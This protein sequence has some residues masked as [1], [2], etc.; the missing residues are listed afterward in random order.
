MPVSY[1]VWLGLALAL[2]GAAFVIRMEYVSDGARIRRALK[3]T[4][5]SEVAS[6]PE[7]QLIKLIGTLSCVGEPLRAPLSERPCSCYE[8][9]VRVEGKNGG[10]RIVRDAARA[11]FWLNDGTGTALVRMKDAK[12]SIHQDTHKR[13]G[14]FKKATPELEAFLHKHGQTSID[15]AFGVSFNRP[16]RYEEGVLEAGET[17]AVVGYATREADVSPG[18][19]PG[20][21]RYGRP[22]R[23]VL[24][25]NGDAMPLYVSDKPDVLHSSA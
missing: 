23:L 4:A 12:V 3:N 18:A 17:V 8:V 16:L 1:Q 5:K 20:D 21:S 9:T 10:H 19:A 7:G 15:V 2:I 22:E 13:S 6:A 24:Q 14:T 25:S 11:D